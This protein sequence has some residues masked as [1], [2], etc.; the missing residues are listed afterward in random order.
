MINPIPKSDILKQLWIGKCTVYEFTPVTDPVTHQTTSKLVPVLEDEPCRLSYSYNSTTSSATGVAVVGQITTL[1][2]RPDVEIK[3]GSIIEVTQH[4]K[5]S[6]F[7]KA[8][9]P[10][11]YTNHQEIVIRLDEDV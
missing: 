6:R 4:G 1:F 8:G 3:S 2:I 9:K 7:N 11:V 10:A 5:V